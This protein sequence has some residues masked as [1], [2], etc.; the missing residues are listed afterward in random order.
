[1][2]AESVATRSSAARN[3]SNDGIPPAFG[4]A[5]RVGIDDRDELRARVGLQNPQAAGPHTAESDEDAPGP[6]RD[7]PTITSASA[8][9]AR[10][11][12]R[13]A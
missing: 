12:W 4:A 13:H 10:A 9:F 11:R 3:V 2:Q 1:M 7:A 6:H 5:R 8:T